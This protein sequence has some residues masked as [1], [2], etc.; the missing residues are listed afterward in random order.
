MPGFLPTRHHS[1]ECSREA[2]LL[3]LESPSL[4]PGSGEQYCLTIVMAA[5]ATTELTKDPKTVLFKDVLMSTATTNRLPI[6]ST[7]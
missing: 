7:F 1:D 2:Q 3:N 5:A 4:P 6:G